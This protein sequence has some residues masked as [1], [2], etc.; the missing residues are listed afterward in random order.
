LRS[1]I[2]LSLLTAAV[3]TC[4][5]IFGNVDCRAN[6]LAE[7]KPLG[8]GLEELDYPYSVVF[9]TLQ[10]EGQ[11]LRMAHM[12]VQP[13][14]PNGQTVVLLHGK[15][16][17]GYYWANTIKVL[18]EAGYRVVV[19]DQIGWGKSSKPDIHYSFDLLAAN[20][21]DLLQQL[22]INKAVV[23]GHSTGG[24]LAM[25]LAR[26]YPELVSK[27]V[28]EDP[29]GLEDYRRKIPPQSD[30][31][32]YKM[33]L[34]NTDPKLI[35]AFFSRYFASPD[36]KLVSPLADVFVRVSKSGEWARWAKA[37]ALAYRMI[38]EQPVCYEFDL[39]Q[40]ATFLVVGEQDKTVVL[41]KYGKPELVKTMG[42]FPQLA[43]EAVSRMPN[44]KLLVIPNCGHIPHLEQADTFHH[45]V[46]EFLR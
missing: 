36:P 25:R 13:L 41:A 16:M 21:A 9:R 23:I 37:S 11:S 40:P 31:T 33:E 30:D 26:T 4:F 7:I 5:P 38:Y 22:G 29:I 8:I 19:P 42:N 20:T 44:G 12:D 6:Q 2:S 14:K 3:L 18:S 35:N 1:Y 43:K 27:L 32:I 15:N 46:L 28:L 10:I 45:A 24:M 39:L 17:G 34:A